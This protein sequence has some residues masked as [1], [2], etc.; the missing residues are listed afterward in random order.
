MS[1]NFPKIH[2]GGFLSHLFWEFSQVCFGGFFEE[3]SRDFSENFLKELIRKFRECLEGF[4]LWRVRIFRRDFS[5][6]LPIFRFSK[7]LPFFPGITSGILTIIGQMIISIILRRLFQ[8]FY[9]SLF[10][11]YS[12]DCTRNCSRKVFFFFSINV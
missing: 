2:S 1:W 8:N 7:Q 5:R 6:N 4:L 9:R 11:N 10:R 3:S 12:R